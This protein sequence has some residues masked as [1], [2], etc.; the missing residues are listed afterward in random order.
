[1]L[2]LSLG[3]GVQSSTLAL[4]AERGEI[5]RPDFALFADTQSE[6]AS[7][8][9][10]LAWLEKQLSY[11]VHRV[12]HGNLSEVALQVRVSAKGNRYQKSAPPAWITENN[13]RV[14]LLVRQCTVDFKIAPIRRHLREMGGKQSGVEQMIG[15]SLDEAHRMKPA[16]DQW[17][18]N[19]WPLIEKRMTRRDC[20]SWMERNGYPRPPRSS[21]WFC[22][23][24]SNEEW[25]RLKNEEPEAFGMAVRWEIEF[26]QTM[27][28]VKGFRGTPYLHRT[29]VPLSEIDFNAP[30]PQLDM[31]GN[32]CEGVCG[33]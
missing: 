17:I 5:D 30:S 14:S 26:Q 21:C 1:M 22:P 13:G 31:F 18:K 19:R 25:R 12:S 29:C 15:I 11:P 33:V 8:Y 24:H 6:P 20:I 2:V 9:R 7:V 10:W 23:Y 28:Q 3:A 4:M 16:K 32:E 27:A